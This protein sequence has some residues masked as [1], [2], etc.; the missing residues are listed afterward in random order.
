[1]STATHPTG[2]LKTAL[3]HAARLLASRPDLAEEQA[4]EIL[5]VVAGNPQARMILARARAAQND[6]QGARDI[7]RDLCK[8][9]KKDGIAHAELGS[10]LARIGDTKGAMAALERAVALSPKLP[11]AWRELGDQ[12]LLAGDAKGADEAYAQHI[13]ASARDPH[14]LEAA[15]ALCDNKLAIAERLLRD[16]LKRHPT[17]V[18]AI[19]MLAETG[20]RL[21]RYED[22]ETLLARCLEL[23]PGFGMARQN[24]ATVLYRQNKAAEAIAQADLLLAEEPGNPG[25]RALKAAA[26]GQIGQYADAVENYEQLLKTH[27]DQPKAWMSYG[28]ALKAI[29][30]QQDC[31]AAYRKSVAL[32]PALGE[33]WWS[34]ANLKILRLALEDIAAMNT[35]L[36]RSDLN[37][38]DRWHLHFALGKALEDQARYGESFRHYS[39]GNRLRRLA[40][41]YEADEITDHVQRSSAFFTRG[42]FRQRNGWGSSAP[43]PIFIIGLPRAGSTLIEQILASHSHVEGTMELPDIVS[44]ARRLGGKWK[45]S[46]RSAYPEALA[47]LD[48]DAVR[49]LGEEYLART[50]I[51][52]R[53]GRPFFIDKMPNNFAH[54]GLIHLILPNAKI[55]DA[56]RHPLACS[57]ALFKQHFARGQGFSYSLDDI[58]RYYADYAAL[59]AHFDSVLPGRIH[60]VFYERLIQDFEGEVRRLLDW[61][62]LPF[63]QT[64]LRFYENARP[65]RTA[66][67]EQVRLPIFTDSLDQWRNYEVWLGPLQSA[68]AAVLSDYPAWPAIA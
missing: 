24:Y 23:A 56:R 17:D 45:R 10:M 27:P 22:A 47:D 29:G 55:I 66:S 49:A 7:L 38:E 19:R 44:I 52:R 39:E 20:S 6:V 40:L 64:C 53:L 15:R 8:S 59:M 60:R 42:F 2:T 4:R 34:L 43:D 67:S 12:R 68:L 54:L 58:A 14:L 48:S 26:L 36:A 63:E 25:F 13:L 33:A 57:F 11:G 31:V 35:Q 46:D 18:A 16:F 21:G 50:R 5:A 37:E 3:E 51:H 65:V 41:D 28:H 61:C 1:V 9:Q 32:L 30:R 62:G